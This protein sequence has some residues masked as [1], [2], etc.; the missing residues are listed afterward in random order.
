MGIFNDIGNFFKEDI[1]DFFTKD[2]DGGI[3][4]GIVDSFD[5]DL[6]DFGR[7]F[8]KYVLTPSLGVF[9]VITENVDCGFLNTDIVNSDH[10]ELNV[11]SG[12]GQI[13]DWEQ[14]VEGNCVSVGVIKAAIDKF[15]SNMFE[16]INWTGSGWLVTT[17]DNEQ[18]FISEDNYRE[19]YESGYFRDNEELLSPELAWFFG[20]VSEDSDGDMSLAVLAYAVLARRR[21][22]ECDITFSDAL[23]DLGDGFWVGNAIHLLGLSDYAIKVDLSSD[24]AKTTILRE[25]NAIFTEHS[26]DSGHAFYCDVINGEIYMDNYGSKK[27]FD[28][29]NSVHDDYTLDSFAWVFIDIPSRGSNSLSDRQYI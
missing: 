2:G 20:Y 1:P 5:K 21:A 4:S 26:S 15:G 28:G 27:S 18:L 14:T 11:A 3:T 13:D 29:S 24:T 10:P 25:G 9:G 7:G 23:T 12:D 19:A 22:D 8:R 16:E 17:H 6:I